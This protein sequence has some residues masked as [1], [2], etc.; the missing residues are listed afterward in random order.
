MSLRIVLL[1]SCVLATTF[2]SEPHPR[3]GSIGLEHP[4][5]EKTREIVADALPAMSDFSAGL[6][7]TKEWEAI[8]YAKQVVAGI[9]YF[10]KVRFQ[11]SDNSETI[12]HLR[13]YKPLRGK[14]K[15]VDIQTEK[16]L[17][18]PITYF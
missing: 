11:L 1:F 14:V 9:N 15:L 17:T 10:V 16:S 18:D 4:A 3:T 12:A 13:I 5:T 7:S 8:S 2:A 6:A